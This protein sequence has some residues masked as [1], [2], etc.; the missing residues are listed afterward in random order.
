MMGEADELG[1]SFNGSFGELFDRI[2]EQRQR[3]AKGLTGLEGFERIQGELPIETTLELAVL[4]L[5][6]H[7]YCGIPQWRIQKTY[8]FTLEGVFQ[9]SW[10]EAWD[11]NLSIRLTPEAAIDIARQ[12]SQQ[13]WEEW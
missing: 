2:T 5:V 1:G 13:D 12:L 10:V 6:H 9:R 8:S 4:T 3:E 11:A 7:R